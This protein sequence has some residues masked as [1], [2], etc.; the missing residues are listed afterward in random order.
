MLIHDQFRKDLII[1]SN[2]VADRWVEYNYDYLVKMKRYVK[3]QLIE[4]FGSIQGQQIMIDRPIVLHKQIP[5]IMAIWELGGGIIVNDLHYTLQQNLA[6]Q[7]Y[8]SSIDICLIEWGDARDAQVKKALAVFE[9]RLH[10]IKYW[11]QDE[12]FNS[13]IDDPIVATENN[14]A[15]IV[16]TS[17]TNRAPQQVSY[18][19]A[20][21]RL[22]VDANRDNYH[23]QPTEHVFH[24]KSFHHGGLC[25]SYFLPTLEVCQHH[26]FG[27]DHQGIDID[28]HAINMIT[29]TPVT[30]FMLP[31]AVSDKLIKGLPAGRKFTLQTTHN[32]QSVQQ[33]DQLFDQDRVERLF[34]LF[35]CRELPAPIFMQDI[36]IDSWAYQ[37]ESWRPDVYDLPAVDFWKLKIFDDGLGVLA[38]YMTDYYVPGDMFI[39]FPNKQWKWQ[40]RNSV[41]KRK[42]HVINPDVVSVVLDSHFS[43]IDKLIV[44]DYEFKKLYAFVF[45]HGESDLTDQFN[46]VIDRDIDTNHRLDLVLGLDK[47][48]MIGFGRSSLSVLRFLARKKLNLVTAD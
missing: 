11:D 3:H 47:K 5:L 46:Q 43:N 38:D 2:E 42:G 17:G 48:D 14:I 37:R 26:Y 12:L 36:D 23:Y 35:G 27:V 4:K 41:I 20:Q 39:S 34:V 25:V 45:G 40:G 44:A 8:Y 21:L 19:H 22:A 24:L 29:A 16:A 31:Y 30:R 28:I 7:D 18:T 10:E 15:L 33:I 6:Y 1:H 32:L 9:N 13:I